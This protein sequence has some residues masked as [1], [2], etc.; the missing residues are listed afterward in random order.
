MI[1]RFPHTDFS[2]SKQGA[3]N[4]AKEIVHRP[5]APGQAHPSQSPPPGWF[6]AAWSSHWLGME[7]PI[8]LRQANRRCHLRP[9]KPLRPQLSP[10]YHLAGTIV[11]NTM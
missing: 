3:V 10:S 2:Y 1:Y 5:A 9:F 8:R 11:I 7:H 6:V 4:G